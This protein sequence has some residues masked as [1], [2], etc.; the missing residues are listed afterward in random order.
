VSSILDLDENP[1]RPMT[2]QSHRRQTEGTDLLT[3]QTKEKKKSSNNNTNTNSTTSEHGQ[4]RNTSPYMDFPHRCYGYG[5][6]S[7][8]WLKGRKGHMLVSRQVRAVHTTNVLDEDCTS[9][10]PF[11]FIPM[12][13]QTIWLPDFNSADR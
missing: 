7:P 10:Q 5:N 11:R 9:Y 4:H 2:P 13:S 1:S 3:K 6:S 8:P 12:L